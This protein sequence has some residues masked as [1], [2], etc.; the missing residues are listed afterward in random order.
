[1]FVFRF[2]KLSKAKETDLKIKI[3]YADFSRF[4]LLFLLSKAVNY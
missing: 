2:I 1:M 3:I 4:I